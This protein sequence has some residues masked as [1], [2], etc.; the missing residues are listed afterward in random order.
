MLIKSL[1]PYELKDAIGHGG[2]GT[3]FLGINRDTS[4]RVAIKVL[5][6]AYAA[7]PGFRERFEAEIQSLEKLK[8][9]HIVELYGYGEES[10]TLYY[11]MELVEGS[12]L[13]KE[14]SDGCR[15]SWRE[16]IDIAVAIC[17]ARP[18]CWTR[19]VGSLAT[20]VCAAKMVRCSR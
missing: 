13:Q 12:N 20:T 14:L 7:D 6:P 1:G 2:M 18:R 11:A 17:A 4:R 10:G 5:A 8:H 19:P 16:V 15:F 3:V 9:P